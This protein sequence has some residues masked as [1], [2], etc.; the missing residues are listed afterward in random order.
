MIAPGG[1]TD[2]DPFAADAGGIRRRQEPAYS[3][4]KNACARSLDGSLEPKFTA[5]LR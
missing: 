1:C 3:Y 2:G 4:I 5:S